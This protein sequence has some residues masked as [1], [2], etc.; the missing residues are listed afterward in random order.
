[1]TPSEKFIHHVDEVLHYIWDPLGVAGVPEARD[2]YRGY[3]PKVTELTN[4][5]DPRILAE[6]LH[7]TETKSMEVAGDVENCLEVAEIIFDWKQVVFD[8][9]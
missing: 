7:E 8:R 1:M 2:E 4:E 9:S 5:G 3:L 6:Y